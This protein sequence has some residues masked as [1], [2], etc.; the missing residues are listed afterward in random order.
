MNAYTIIHDILTTPA[1]SFAFVFSILWLIG[2]LIHFSSSKIATINAEHG[3]LKKTN[4]KIESKIDDIFK[5]IAKT[6]TQKDINE[7]QKDIAFLKGIFGN[8]KNEFMQGHSPLSLTEKGNIVSKEM[9]AEKRISVN[10]ELIC[11]TIDKEI[12]DKNPY[13]IQQYCL[14]TMVVEPEKFFGE[15]DLQELKLYAYQQGKNFADIAV[16]LAIIIRDRYFAEHG[17]E[18]DSKHDESLCEAENTLEEMK[19]N[20]EKIIK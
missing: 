20:V 18:V 15:K 14:E 7:L 17:I 10:W 19:G 9:N 6:V 3:H 16:V 8:S 12:Q 13:D 4:D 5:E 1:G 2:K 11:N